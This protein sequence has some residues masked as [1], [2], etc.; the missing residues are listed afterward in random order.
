MPPCTDVTTN[1]ATY[2]ASAGNGLLLGFHGKDYIVHEDSQG[3]VDVESFS[4]YRTDADGDTYRSAEAGNVWVD[5]YDEF[6]EWES[7]GEDDL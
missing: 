7:E 6:M 3:F 4:M 2:K 5:L 1:W